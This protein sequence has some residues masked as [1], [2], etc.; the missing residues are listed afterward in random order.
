[1]ITGGKRFF[2]LLTMGLILVLVGC[3]QGSDQQDNLSI[4]Q[5]ALIMKLNLKENA[6][7]ILVKSV[8]VT[9]DGVKDR[10]VLIGERIDEQ[11]KFFDNLIVGVQDGK[12]EEYSKATYQNFSGYEPEMIFKDFSG[13]K[14]KDVM[15]TADAGGSGNVANH[16]IASFKD[17]KPKVIFDEKNN[18]GV[19][20]SGSFIQEFKARLKFEDIKKEGVLDLSANREEYIKQNIYNKDGQLVN[21]MK[22]TPYSNYFSNLEAIDYNGDGKYELK[23]YQK[24]VGAYNADKISE[25]KS[26]WEYQDGK[27]NLKELQY[28]TFLLRYNSN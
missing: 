20:V 9:G 10:I 24:V 16:L 12:S 27:W 21:K 13:D 11:S 3:S 19:T 25:L 4:D 7:I 8:D 22:I 23:G 14:I 18:K 26:I 5:K 17:N 2:L 1:M 28:S 6:E 15:V